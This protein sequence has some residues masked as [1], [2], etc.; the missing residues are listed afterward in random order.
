MRPDREEE[1]LCG[2]TC[3]EGPN[4]L[5]WET[6]LRFFR[7]KSHRGSSWS[8]VAFQPCSSGLTR[9]L[10]LSKTQ[11][12][13][14]FLPA[15]RFVVSLSGVNLP[16]A[17]ALVVEIRKTLP[18]KRLGWKGRGERGGYQSSWSAN[19]NWEIW[20]RDGNCCLSGHTSGQH[21]ENTLLSSGAESR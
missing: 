11:K 4:Q 21:L 5:D 18:A 13:T 12:G 1:N 20:G 2:L 6:F 7:R 3:T 19:W 10:Q 8:S 16:A 15:S 17:R 14:A 9:N